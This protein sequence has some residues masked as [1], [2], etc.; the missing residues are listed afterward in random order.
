MPVPATDP[1]AP[2]EATPRA[3][4]PWEPPERLWIALPAAH[5]VPGALE[6]ARDAVAGLVE[7]VAA[8][9]PVTVLVDPDDD[10]ARR[11]LP[12]AAERIA[13]RVDTPLLGRTGPTFV[14]VG[15]AVEAVHWRPLPPTGPD[16]AEAA[17][18][19]AGP[20]PHDALVAAAIARA[21]GLHHRAP[22]LSAPPAT[23]ATDGDG[24]AVVS[25]AVL[26]PA[27][28]GGW[29]REQAED[30]L[31]ALLG[32]SRVLWLPATGGRAAGP[33]AG[34]GHPHPWLRFTA[35]G[36]VA[37]HWQQGRLHPDHA[38]GAAALRVLTD[39]VD[40]RGRAL[41][42]QTVAAA[43]PGPHPD[44]AARGPLSVLDVV[45]LGDGHVLRPAFDDPGAEEAAA[46]TA[47]SLCPGA[48][49]VAFPQAPLLRLLGSLSDL[50]LVQPRPATPAGPPGAR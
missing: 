9:A 49:Q 18:P 41:A 45:P 47:E 27:V 34:T 22:L 17:S 28:N 30:A 20:G 6:E 24:T 43:P 31:A 1:E 35:P 26:D 46:A 19:A 40:A 38:P 36:R 14:R 5:P 13:Q 23:W 37:V 16:R 12:A 29:T 8:V 11:L 48:A 42:V 21:A 39:A 4:A 7:S 32:V 3:A 33:Y 44:P 10:R 2:H 15:R 50:V 25:A